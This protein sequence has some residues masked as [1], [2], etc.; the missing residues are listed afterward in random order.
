MKKSKILSYIFIGVCLSFFLQSIISEETY[1]SDFEINNNE[2]IKDG[3]A[4]DFINASRQA[5]QSVVHIKSKYISNEVYGYYDPFYGKRFFNKPKEN[6]ANGSGVIISKDG[7]LPDAKN[8][9]WHNINIIKYLKTKP[10][11]D[12]N[13]D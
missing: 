12:K 4:P 2:V 1:A 7:Y 6:I 3:N 11:N 10:Y 8:K 5:I 13:T 9:I